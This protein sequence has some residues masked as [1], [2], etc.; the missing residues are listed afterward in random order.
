M[1]ITELADWSFTVE[2]KNG[3][4]KN[5]ASNSFDYYRPKDEDIKEDTITIKF[6][7]NE[8]YKEYE[9]TIPLVYVSI[10]ETTS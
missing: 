9:Y 4:I 1:I 6:M 5:I 8:N 7:D 10:T 3:K 2:S